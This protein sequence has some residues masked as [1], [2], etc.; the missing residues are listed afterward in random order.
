VSIPTHYP[1]DLQRMQ[2]EYNKEKTKMI[3]KKSREVLQW[4]KTQQ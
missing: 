1:D 3:V 4:L 2:K